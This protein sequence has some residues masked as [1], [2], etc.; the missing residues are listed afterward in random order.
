RQVI[1]ERLSARALVEG[2]NFSFG[3][4]RQGTIDTLTELCRQTGLGIQVVPPVLFEGKPV[5]SSR[6]RNALVAG[7]VREAARLLNRPYRLHGTVGRGQQRGRTIGFPTANLE[8]AQTLVPGDGVYAVRV[9]TGNT[10][11]PGAANV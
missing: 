10:A 3:R 11:W 7:A 2:A 5:S 4:D 8:Q 6:V 9:F 1:C